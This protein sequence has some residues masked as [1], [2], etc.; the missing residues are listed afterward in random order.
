MKFA[1]FYAGQIIEEGPYL[2]SEEELLSF[3]KS[4]DPQWFHVQPETAAGGPF[5]GLIASGWQ[6]C[7]IAMNLMVKAALH[8][9]ESFASPGLNYLKW[10]AP[11]R[12]G[13][14][15]S[16]KAT[17]LETRV[18]A[19]KPTLGVL[20]WR[21]QLFNQDKVEVL[22]LEATSLFDLTRSAS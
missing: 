16:V 2:L 5:K 12:A 20:R 1:Q 6:S 21:W 9:S 3:A 8:D 4:Y 13:D 18:S 22:D 7:G 17:V 15:L 14:S 11:V 10:L 19:S